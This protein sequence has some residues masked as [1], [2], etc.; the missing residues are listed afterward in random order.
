MASTLE[1]FEVGDWIVHNHYGVGEIK[2]VE[3]RPIHG[4]DTECFRVETS[5]ATYW[6]PVDNAENARTRRVVNKARFQRALRAL[7]GKPKEM[8]K[9][10]RT[11]NAK[12]R[13]VL[14]ES[15]SLEKMAALLRDLLNLREKKKWNN[16]EKDAVE[17]IRKRMVREWSA[18]RDIPVEEAKTKLQT[19]VINNFGSA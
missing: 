16:T 2:K 10:Y 11:R 3:E 13:E 6:L 5:D 18:S 1:T 12:I 9:N 7:K 4:E 8:A 19:I 14:Y 15:G 17:K